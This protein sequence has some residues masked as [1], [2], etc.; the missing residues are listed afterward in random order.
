M[1]RIGI[2]FFES[3]EGDIMVCVDYTADVYTLR[4]NSYSIGPT[5]S[6][7]YTAHGFVANVV[8]DVECSTHSERKKRVKE[9]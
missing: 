9:T 8:V 6:A 1:R 5:C 3:I 2:F 7:V 4:Y